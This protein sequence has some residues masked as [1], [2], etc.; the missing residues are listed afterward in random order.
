MERSA[1]L[2]LLPGTVVTFRGGSY[3]VMSVRSGSQLEAPFF[4][5]RNLDHGHVTGPVSHK[6]IEVSN[7]DA[8]H[9]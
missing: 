3:Q 5:L 8:P 4:R 2:R 7:G 9:G 6:L 1:A